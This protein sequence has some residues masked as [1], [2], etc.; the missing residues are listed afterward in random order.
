MGGEQSGRR[1]AGRV[2][3]ARLFAGFARA[4]R[5]GGRRGTGPAGGGG[6]VPGR[7]GHDQQLPAAAAR[8]GRVGPAPPAGRPARDRAG[9]V[10]S[11]GGTGAGRPRRHA[12]AAL[13]AVGGGD[14]AGGQREHD[15]AD[16]RARRLDLQAKTLGAAERDEVT[17]RAWRD[18]VAAWD[19]D[20]VVVLAETGT[21]A[22]MTPG[23][24]RAPRNERAYDLAPFNT[25][26]N[27]TTLAVVTT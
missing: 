5:G 13:R 15:V 10:P 21:H 16:D 12:G 9:A 17:R 19:P 8:D 3:D 4:H 23:H 7:A 14:R 24:A 25:G 2:G 20:G 27:I 11:A 1:R 18:E 26:D 22:A 6:A